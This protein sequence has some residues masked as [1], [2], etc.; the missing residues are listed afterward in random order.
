LKFKDADPNEPGS[1]RTIVA[2]GRV[3]N[4]LPGAIIIT[5]LNEISST[6]VQCNI[7]CSQ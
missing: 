3:C 4:G 1:F 5:N 2:K 6:P 7:S